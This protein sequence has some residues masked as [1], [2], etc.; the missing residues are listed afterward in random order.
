MTTHNL[1]KT[2][3][4]TELENEILHRLSQTDVR[5]HQKV[6]PGRELA[7]LFG[8][9]LSRVQRAIKRLEQRGYFRTRVGSGVY[10]TEKG[11]AAIRG[12]ARAESA[13]GIPARTP[14]RSMHLIGI[15][16]VP[17]F[18][19]LDVHVPVY[20]EE[21]QVAMWT[22]VFDA[23]RRQFPFLRLNVCF[24]ATTNQQM[25]DVCIQGIHALHQAPQIWTPLDRQV[26]VKAGAIESDLV[27]GILKLGQDPKTGRL[28]G[29]PLL[30]ASSLIMVNQALLDKH[31]LGDTRPNTLIDLFRLGERLEINSNGRILGIN[32][33]GVSHYSRLYGVTVDEHDGRCDFDRDRMRRFLSECKPFMRPHHFE[34]K[35]EVAWERFLN[36][37][38]G[39]FFWYWPIYPIVQEYI[40]RVESLPIPLLDGGVAPESVIIGSVNRN[41]RHAEEA[42]LLVGF[43]ASE[44]AQSLFTEQTPQWLSVHAHV[45]ARQQ[46][47]SPFA[48]G[49]VRYGFDPRS[50]YTE[51]NPN[52]FMDYVAKQNTEAG[53][54]F[55]G[56]QSLDETL[57]KLTLL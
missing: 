9:S 54:F 56:V 5:A 2:D 10:V 52:L 12:P 34:C 26:L 25:T 14:V 37:Q 55:M 36:G 29:L 19:T 22:R 23:F 6:L 1:L 17:R 48:P 33:P 32:F 45:L 7:E 20:Q 50:C 15:P 53:K 31:G 47:S 24:D 44:T 43:L 38:F 28:L 21:H 18:K 27:E 35:N 46:A 57:D 42:M 3:A 41:T 8:T 4:A 11:A 49:A 51:L 39:L 30:R 40:K 13:A 16:H